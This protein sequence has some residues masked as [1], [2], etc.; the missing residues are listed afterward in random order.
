MAAGLAAGL[1]GCGGEK[2]EPKKVSAEKPA[3]AEVQPAKRPTVS[4]ALWGG[5]LQ[6]GVTEF[7]QRLF[8]TIEHGWPRI[9]DGTVHIEDDQLE[10]HTVSFETSVYTSQI[11]FNDN[12]VL[13]AVGEICVF[14]VLPYSFI[15]SM[16]VSMRGVVTLRNE[17]ISL[18]S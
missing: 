3:A 10:V 11:S 9:A 1:A 6:I 17:D 13:K 4:V 8:V 16:N 15:L 18:I 7:L 14:D 2:T 12:S 5:E